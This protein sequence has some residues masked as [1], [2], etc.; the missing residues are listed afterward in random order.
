MWSEIGVCSR[1]PNG[2]VREHSPAAAGTGVSDRVRQPHLLV[3]PPSAAPRRHNR[4]S[5]VSTVPRNTAQKRAPGIVRRAGDATPPA[6]GRWLLRSAPRRKTVLVRNSYLCLDRLR[7]V[8]AVLGLP[9]RGASVLG[10]FDDGF[11]LAVVEIVVVHRGAQKQKRRPLLDQL[12]P[13]ASRA[14]GSRSGATALGRS[15]SGCDA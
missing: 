8:S 2:E 5:R 3:S 14:I 15:T 13:A 7:S 10:P 6:R 11:Y 12:L 4:P 9:G 1:H